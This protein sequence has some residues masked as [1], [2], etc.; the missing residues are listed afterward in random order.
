MTQLYLVVGIW[1]D[2]HG[3]FADSCEADSPEEAEA[4]IIEQYTGE[5]AENEGACLIVAGVIALS[6][7]GEMMVVA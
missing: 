3:R 4:A 6:K 1:L 2:D 5:G 7:G